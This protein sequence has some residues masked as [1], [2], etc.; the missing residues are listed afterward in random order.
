MAHNFA[1]ER[2]RFARRSPRRSATRNNLIDE[3]QFAVCPVFIGDGRRLLDGVSTRV[4]PELL[5]AKPL[6][7]GDL[8]LRYARAG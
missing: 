8:M 1:V 4:R 7:S 5:E 2:P 3:Y 6:P